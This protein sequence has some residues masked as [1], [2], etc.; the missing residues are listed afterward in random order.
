MRLV[1]RCLLWHLPLCAP[2]LQ[3]NDVTVERAGTGPGT[4]GSGATSTVGVNEV[5]PND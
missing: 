5:I 2:A 3:A 4:A 1:R